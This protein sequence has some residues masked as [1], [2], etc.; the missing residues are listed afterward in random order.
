MTDFDRQRERIESARL[1]TRIG[2]AIQL[3]EVVGKLRYLATRLEACGETEDL[4]SADT[5]V[6][7]LFDLD[8]IVTVMDK[9]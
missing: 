7:A 6:K 2:V 8:R 9:R 3:K 5:L 4:A 1:S